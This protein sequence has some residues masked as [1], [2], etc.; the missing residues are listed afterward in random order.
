MISSISGCSRYSCLAKCSASSLSIGSSSK[1]I[2]RPSAVLPV[3]MGRLAIP[4]EV[5]TT[6]TTFLLLF[7]VL[8][9]AG[10]ALPSNAQWKV[11][12][13]AMLTR[14]GKQVSPENAWQ[15]YPRPQFIRD[16]KW[17][18]LNGLWDYAVTKKDQPQNYDG[19]ILVTKCEDPMFWG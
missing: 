7:F 2:L 10:L 15:E 8:F 11:P 13:D 9:A 1:R 17:K 19:K 12:D 16:G 4:D 5:V 6:V 18:S 14:W 3:R